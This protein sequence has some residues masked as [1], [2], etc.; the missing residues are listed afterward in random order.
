[1]RTPDDAWAMLV[2]AVDVI[3][4]GEP[5]TDGRAVLFAGTWLTDQPPADLH[6]GDLVIPTT[7]ATSPYTTNTPQTSRY[8]WL[9]ENAGW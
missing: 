2:V 1:M 6:D 5:D 4:V 9:T 7:M 8:C 3:D